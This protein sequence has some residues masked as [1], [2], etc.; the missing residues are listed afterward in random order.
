M[1]SRV[2][3][4]LT[5][6]YPYVKPNW[7]GSQT[8]VPASISRYHLPSGGPNGAGFIQEQAG[9]TADSGR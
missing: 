8:I 3:D 9:A 2:S 1:R 7:F 5:T 4:I 6:R